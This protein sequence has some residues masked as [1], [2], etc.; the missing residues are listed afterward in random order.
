MGALEW[1]GRGKV[2]LFLIFGKKF[3]IINENHELESLK[4][5]II[6]ERE[7]IKK[8]LEIIEDENLLNAIRELLEFA[9]K[10]SVREQFV[11]MSLE[12]FRRRAEESERAIREG[13]VASVEDVER[14]SSTW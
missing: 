10:K 12:E 11:P 9:K 4:M 7:T 3:Y 2:F 14:E 13:R 1:R 8:E 5:N 6:A